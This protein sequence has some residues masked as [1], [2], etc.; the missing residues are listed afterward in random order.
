MTS[1]EQK[2]L[3]SGVAAGTITGL[4][5]GFLIALFIAMKLMGAVSVGGAVAFVTGLVAAAMFITL[6]RQKRSEA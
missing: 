1:G 5:V 2:M 3:L 6:A 4:A